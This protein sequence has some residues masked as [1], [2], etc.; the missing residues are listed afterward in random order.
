MEPA[1]TVL[2]TQQ[3]QLLESLSSHTVGLEDVQVQVQ[4]QARVQVPGGGGCR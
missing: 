2:V 3:L 1:H 4:V